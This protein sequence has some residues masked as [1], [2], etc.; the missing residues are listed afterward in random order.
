MKV[1]WNAEEQKQ[2]LREVEGKLDTAVS[3]LVDVKAS[4]ARWEAERAELRAEITRWQDRY[5]RQ[6]SKMEK[7]AVRV[8]RAVE[9]VAGLTPPEVESDL[10]DVDHEDQG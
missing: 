5:F 6:Q 1:W 2:Q 7:L 3:E 10:D 4:V 9:A 8:Q